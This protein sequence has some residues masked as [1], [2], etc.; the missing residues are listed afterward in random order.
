[1]CYYFLDFS[2]YFLKSGI[3]YFVNT[4]NENT[5]P[6]HRVHVHLQILHSAWEYQYYLF[7]DGNCSLNFGFRVL[8]QANLV[9]STI[10]EIGATN[11]FPSRFQSILNNMSVIHV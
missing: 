10:D 2:Y 9:K 8:S 5:G 7:V 11:L 4:L 3:F 6:G 1:M